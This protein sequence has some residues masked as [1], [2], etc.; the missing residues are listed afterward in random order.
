[1]ILTTYNGTTITVNVTDTTVS[2][3]ANG[4]HRHEGVAVSHG[5]RPVV[6]ARYSDG[7]WIKGIGPEMVP[8]TL[9]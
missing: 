1:M 4:T 3:L 6:V 5:G 8:V 7:W 2:P 9:N